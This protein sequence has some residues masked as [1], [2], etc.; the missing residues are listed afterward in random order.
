[1]R[2]RRQPE[3]L[4]ELCLAR[5]GVLKGGRVQAFIAQW[6]IATAALGRPI[7]V[8]EYAEWWRESER[9]TY[10]HQACFRELFPDHDTPQV[11]ADAAIATQEDATRAG[12]KGLGQLPAAI[13]PA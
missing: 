3:T 9:T 7:T 4:L 6:T 8:I 1:M 10:R 11:I 5:G 2:L 13:V 12:I